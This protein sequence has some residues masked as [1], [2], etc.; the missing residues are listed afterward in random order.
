[1]YRVAVRR[2]AVL[3]GGFLGVWLFLRYLFPL[4]LPFVAGLLLALAA[5]PAVRLLTRAKLPRWA[6]TGIGVSLTLILLITLVSILGAALVRQVGVLARKLPDLQ[7]TARQTA[8]KLQYLLHDAA[9]HAPENLRPLAERSVTRLFS[10]NSVIFQQLTVRLP[11]AVSSFLSRVPAG[12]LGIGTGLLS[13]FMFSVRLPKLK[14]WLA[15]K[16]PQGIRTKVLPGLKRSK[17]AL[18]GWLKAQLKLCSITFGILCLGFLLL[19]IPLAPLWAALVAVVDAVPVLGTGAV[20]VPWALVSMLQHKA[21][22][23]VGLL[24][25]WGAA[26]VTRTAL[27]PRLVGRQ[28]GLDPLV[29]LVF[30]YL[31]YRFWGILGMLIAPMI[32]AALTA[33][34]KEWNVEN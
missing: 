8:D 3:V 16:M 2:T 34:M 23:S 26:L 1:M 13:G 15:E 33:A 25:L 14:H 10:D 27:E 4:A 12:A 28:L 22:Q 24:C 19:R 29:T 18:L 30:L 31:G 6:A 32:A 17:T 5:E 11:G 9:T 20:L 21:L 7:A